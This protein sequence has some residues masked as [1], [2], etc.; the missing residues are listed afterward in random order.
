MAATSI[1]HLPGNALIGCVLRRGLSLAVVLAQ[2]FALHLP[3]RERT[4]F[5]QPWRRG[6]FAQMGQDFVD[7]T[8]V[9]DEGDDSPLAAACS[10]ERKDLIDPRE[11]QC[12]GETGGVTEDRFRFPRCRAACRRTAPRGSA[13]GELE[14]HEEDFE[15]CPACRSVTD[16][17][18]AACMPPTG[19]VLFSRLAVDQ[20]R[21]WREVDAPGFDDTLLVELALD[22]LVAHQRE[23]PAPQEERTRIPLPVHTRG[24][25][26][27]VAL[28]A[29][30]AR[31]QPS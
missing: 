26:T 25:A 22:D 12:P 9:G 13:R 14:F 21:S 10:D 5:H 6:R 1:Q 15:F 3:E 27:I 20:Q 7:G 4:G 17:L 16:P 30:R 2:G 8:G 18:M 29:R 31:V 19:G 28:L 23:D 11:Q 24:A